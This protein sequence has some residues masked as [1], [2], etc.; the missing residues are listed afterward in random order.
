[1]QSSSEVVVRKVPRILLVVNFDWFFLSHR[2]PVARAAKAAGAEVVVVAADTGKAEAVRQQGLEFVPLPLCPRG[3][4]PIDDLRTLVF[5]SRLYR[6]LRP[7]LVHHVSIKPVL[8]GSLAAR[9]IGQVGVVNAIS[10]LGYMFG[11]D[12]R[13][14]LLRPLLKLLYRVALHHPNSR[15]IF[16]NPDDRDDFVSW[17]FVR[18]HRTVLIRGSGVDC[19]VFRPTPQP[20]DTQP[21]VMLACRMRWDKGVSEFV[22]AARYLRARGQNARFVLVGAPDLGSPAALSLAQLEAWAREGIV[23]WWGHR[24]DMPHV[25]ASA[26]L[27]VLPT[28]LREGVPKVLL[29][30]A[31]SERAIV[32]TNTRGCREIVRPDV[33]G[34]LVPPGQSEA[35]AWSIQTLLE[36]RELRAKFGRAG[37]QIAVAEFSQEIVVEQTL[38]VYSELLGARWPHK[39]DGTVI[40]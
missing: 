10:G 22:K 18:K 35:L 25:L 12:R 4:N 29:E 33:N 13:A 14:K 5:L 36:S 1:M 15:T 38:G 11:A 24:D 19:S 34:L 32:A 30:A 37:R 8:Y 31:A 39:T 26:S 40:Y 27:V 17:H 3:M 21:I 7:D 23:E 20:T 6:R 2:L 28:T 9:T 16:Q